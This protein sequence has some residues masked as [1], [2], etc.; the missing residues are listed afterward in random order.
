M[1]TSKAE[2]AKRKPLVVQIDPQ[3]KRDFM[4]LCVRRGSTMTERL[5]YLIERDLRSDQ[6]RR[7]RRERRAGAE[8]T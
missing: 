6:Q 8:A 3:R 2:L 7:E 5:T 1:A 4:T